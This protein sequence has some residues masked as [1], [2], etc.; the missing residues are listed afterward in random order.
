MLNCAGS[1]SV[2]VFVLM[3]EYSPP[4]YELIEGRYLL[5]MFPWHLAGFLE[6]PSVFSFCMNE[7]GNRAGVTV[8]AN[9]H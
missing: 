7:Y 4:N 1:L 8:T 9:V 2:L 5:F 6:E 3:Y